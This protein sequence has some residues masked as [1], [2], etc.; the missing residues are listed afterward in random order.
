MLW[1]HIQYVYEIRLAMFN[2]SS[3]LRDGSI[4]HYFERCSVGVRDTNFMFEFGIWVFCH[5]SN[6]ETAKPGRITSLEKYSFLSSWK[7]WENF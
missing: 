7:S 5:I 1:Y 2:V 6:L 3:T 4:Q